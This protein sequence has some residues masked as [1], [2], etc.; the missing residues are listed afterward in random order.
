MK[1]WVSTNLRARSADASGALEKNAQRIKGLT[2]N[3]KENV[4]EKIMRPFQTALGGEESPRT[5][6]HEI[7]R[8]RGD[9]RGFEMNIAD[10]NRRIAHLE[11]IADRWRE[12]S[13]VVE[14]RDD[15]SGGFDHSV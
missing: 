4:F 5:K 14:D 15:R 7:G 12:A 13:H 3:L 11:R 1:K 6:Q 2:E 9:L 10:L 8:A